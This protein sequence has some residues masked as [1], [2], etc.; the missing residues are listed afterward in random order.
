MA[1]A[2]GPSQGA[3]PRPLT[4]RG[5]VRPCPGRPPAS[6][7]HHPCPQKQG[8][9]IPAPAM[10]T[11]AAQREAA[12]ARED[13]ARR[14]P[15]GRLDA[16]SRHVL[17]ALTQREAAERVQ[18]GPCRDV[19]GTLR[20][21]PRGRTPRPGG[22]RRPATHPAARTHQAGWRQE[23]VDPRDAPHALQAL[24]GLD[25]DGAQGSAQ[26]GRGHRHLDAGPRRPGQPLPLVRP[27]PARLPPRRARRHGRIP[28][29][30]PGAGTG[31]HEARA[32]MGGVRGVAAGGSL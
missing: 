28:R 3:A 29:A 31:G 6:P 25:G 27:C 30:G 12:G 18:R 2:G 5:R 22:T 13:A 7:R 17:G 14:D 19:D 1:A 15:A 9:P 24:L 4:L 20:R 23:A 21:E 26:A 16:A 8:R 32:S 10:P 11:G